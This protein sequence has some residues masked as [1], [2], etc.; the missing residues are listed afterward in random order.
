MLSICRLLLYAMECIETTANFT[1]NDSLYFC[2]FMQFNLDIL[3]H[4]LSKRKFEL[5]RMRNIKTTH[6][7]SY[8]NNET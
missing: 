5:L 3:N 1:F 6:F 7:S 2:V 4:D 8:M